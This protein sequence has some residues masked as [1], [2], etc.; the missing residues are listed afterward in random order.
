MLHIKKLLIGV[1][2]ILLLTF[3]C[4]WEFGAITLGKTEQNE[5]I[6]TTTA[7]SDQ[8]QL[9]ECVTVISGSKQ[10]KLSSRLAKELVNKLN[11]MGIKA[12]FIDGKGHT[13][14]TG[15]NSNALVVVEVQSLNVGFIPVYRKLNGNFKIQAFSTG[16]NGDT[17]LESEIEVS[18]ATIGLQNKRGA[19]AA[20]FS[21]IADKT[22]DS[23]SKLTILNAEKSRQ[24]YIETNNSFVQKII[25]V[26]NASAG[27][28]PHIY[29]INKAVSGKSVGIEPPEGLKWSRSATLDS[30]TATTYLMHAD[31]EIS[32][33]KLD[34]L[35]IPFLKRIAPE[36]E[37]QFSSGGSRDYSESYSSKD[38]YVKFMYSCNEN[39]MVEGA[40][41]M[42]VKFTDKGKL[43]NS[44]LKINR[45]LV[46]LGILAP[47]EDIP[48]DEYRQVYNESI[49]GLSENDGAEYKLL[50]KMYTCMEE[51]Y[52]G[53]KAVKLPSPESI[54]VKLIKENTTLDAITSMYLQQAVCD[55]EKY[56]DLFDWCAMVA[57]NTLSLDYQV[58]LEILKNAYPEQVN[59]AVQ[60][61]PVVQEESALNSVV[62]YNVMAT[63]DI[64]SMWNS[65]NSRAL[66]K[67]ALNEMVRQRASE[68]SHKHVI[69]NY[70][71]Y[72]YD[73]YVASTFA[74][75]E[76]IT[77]EKQSAVERLEKALSS[78]YSRARELELRVLISEMYHHMG[79]EDKWKEMNETIND[80]FTQEQ[81]E[82]AKYLISWR[83]N[84]VYPF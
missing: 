18:S 25:P 27:A 68:N 55:K 60:R 64:S 11:S 59:H 74:I 78:N 39:N 76:W 14:I 33:E 17:S 67:Y 66:S 57:Q 21:K 12:I 9:W 49:I 61:Y 81:V 51:I 28:E 32:K 56:Q 71:H 30:D 50:E 58:L 40:T 6:T 69:D 23:L 54:D 48:F 34:S 72:K 26:M 13:E 42:Y 41:L 84:G 7:T 45:N 80:K 29:K 1:L 52:N 24:G 20:S 35:F 37:K 16:V 15:F 77:G 79:T 65:I 46:D 73:D 8:N 44:A 62:H 22:A 31:T 3:I 83:N 38:A 36:C 4:L 53:N 70:S 10:A 43:V 5:A 47:L 2:L 63:N 75:C 82:R 19:I